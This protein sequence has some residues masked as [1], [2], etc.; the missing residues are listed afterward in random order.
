ML[1]VGVASSGENIAHEVISVTRE[2]CQQDA[3]IRRRA[4]FSSI[5]ADEIRTA[6][7]NLSTPDAQVSMA[8]D[9]RQELDLKVMNVSPF[10]FLCQF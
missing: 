5:S 6:F 3:P 8:V 9:A 10:L 4:R 7:R 1:I 2:A